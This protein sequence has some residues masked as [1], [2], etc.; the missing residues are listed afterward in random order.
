L[1]VQTTAEALAPSLL[2]RLAQG[3][4]RFDAAPRPGPIPAVVVR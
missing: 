3:L 4:S 1:G 2:M